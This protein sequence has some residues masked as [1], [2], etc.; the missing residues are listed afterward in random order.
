MSMLSIVIPCYGSEHTIAAVVHETVQVIES[1]LLE[2]EY[3]FILVNDCGPDRAGEVIERLCHEDPRHLTGV[4]LSRNFGQ[5]SALMAGYA[6]ASGDVVVSMDDDGQMP[7]E[8]LP[9]MIAALQQGPYDVVFARYAVKEHSL[10]RNWGSWVNAQMARYLL[11]KPKELKV[12]SFFVMRRFVVDEMLQ[13]QGPYPYLSG[14]IFRMTRNI[15]TV[16]VKHR[17]RTVGRSGYTVRKLLALWINGFTAFSVKPLRLS[18]ILGVVSSTVGFMYALYCIVCKLVNPNIQMGY[19]SLMAGMLFIGGII[20]LM[21][22][23]IGEYVGRIYI[24]L[25]NSPQYVIRQVVGKAS[26]TGLR[27]KEGAPQA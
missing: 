20:M 19:A 22:G 14:L 13:Y 5:Q 17:K 23:M 16:P 12:T 25:N 1:C 21:M 11:G 24:C 15:G 8:S 2:Y 4:F 9:E 18:S 3:E 10:V 6:H 7:V 27:S 26:A